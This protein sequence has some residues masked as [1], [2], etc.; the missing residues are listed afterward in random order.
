MSIRK[1]A[2]S[3]AITLAGAAA[4]LGLTGTATA[5]VNGIA[6]VGGPNL[7]GASEGLLNGAGIRT[8]NDHVGH[9]NLKGLVRN[10]T[11]PALGVAFPIRLP[12]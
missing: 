6:D 4:L 12:H 2:A 1:I 7:S 11:A 3:A 10:A 5:A 8:V 9:V